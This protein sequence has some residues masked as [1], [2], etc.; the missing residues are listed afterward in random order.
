MRNIPLLN[1]PAFDKATQ[2]LRALGYSVTS[3]AEKDLDAGYSATNQRPWIECACED[4]LAVLQSDA[5]VVLP[6]WENSRGT[7]FEIMAALA[8]DNI[9]PILEYPS[10]K[11]I[12]DPLERIIAW[13][14]QKA[15]IEK[16]ASD[17]AKSFANGMTRALN[18]GIEVPLPFPE[19]AGAPHPLPVTD[20][21]NPKDLIGL[22]KAPLRLVP[23]ALIIF[24][25]KVMG[26]GAKKYGP[27][28]WRDKKVRH[29]VYL[30][31]ALRHILSAMDGEDADPE[32]GMPHE[33]HA[34]ACMGIILDAKS[35]DGLINDRPRPGAASRLISD[36][37]EKS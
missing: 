18:P 13:Q 17:S 26:L 22:K 20:T 35:L 24:V 4:A 16:T 19:H 3:P 32:S 12:F 5:I 28:N 9:I 29:T 2:H 33:A 37:T 25:S 21:S 8:A 34:A 30:E 7:R 27:Y 6:G 23:P 15:E 31:A 14:K 1:F 10:L 11:P 36:M